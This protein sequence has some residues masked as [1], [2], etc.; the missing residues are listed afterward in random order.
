MNLGYI[1]L[2]WLMTN[3]FGPLLFALTGML[4]SPGDLSLND[5]L[6]MS[7]F[8]AGLSLPLLLVMIL[9]GAYLGEKLKDVRKL[10]I[11]LLVT[12]LILMT[13]VLVLILGSLTDY[14]DL[15]G[16]IVCYAIAMISF[17]FIF[18]IKL[19]LPPGNPNIST[20]PDPKL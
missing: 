11:R 7:L 10:R 19:K 14:I 16:L 17:A 2:V 20:S 9:T 3:L 8:G 1:F 12:A 15:A 5:A 4:I 18:K 13:I 6:T